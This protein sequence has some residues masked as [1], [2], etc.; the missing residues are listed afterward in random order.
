MLTTV[1]T[2]LGTLIPT[3]LQNS[4]VIGAGTNNLITSLIA[5]LES[6]FTSL[7]TGTTK[8]SDGLAALAAIQG[9]INV[10]K[11]TTNLPPAVLTQI[12]NLDA[13]VQ[14]ALTA[15]AVAGQGFDSSIYAP[16]AEV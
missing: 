10:L 8:T 7:K 16:I 1:L 12:G 5:P 15:Y 4:G 2:L 6:L 3:I 14:A 13:D 9:V 11:A